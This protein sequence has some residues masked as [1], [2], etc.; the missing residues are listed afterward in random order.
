M[1]IS[2]YSIS[3]NGGYYGGPPIPLLETIPMA[4]GWGY[5]GI[6]LEGKRPHGSPLDLRY[7]SCVPY[8]FGEGRAFQYSFVPTAHK[9]SKVPWSP[10]DNYL[11]EAMV[12][13]LAEE[14]VEFDFMIQLQTDADR[15]P[16]ENASVIWPESYSPWIRVA[17]LHIPAQRFDSEQQL[18]FARQISVNPWHCVAEHRPL[19]NQNRARRYV[20]LETSK[21]RQRINAEPRVES[22]GDEEFV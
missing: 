15:M 20:Y 14:A 19:G 18:A 21:V 9:R 1:K 6:E 17:K 3:L 11:R 2:F 10:S 13:L 7:W 4:K 5:D 16:I 22:T 8:A 12:K